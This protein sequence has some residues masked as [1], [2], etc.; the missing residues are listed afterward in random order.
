[1][2]G[3]VVRCNITRDVW[4][5]LERLFFSQSK[6]RTMQL[7]MALQ[8][9]RKGS[10]TME[11]YFLKMHSLADQLSAIGQVVTDDDL[12]MYILAGLGMEYEALVVNF[13]ERSESP[14]LQEMHNAF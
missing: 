2:L 5:T 7:Q 11:E 8:T 3:H 10:L 13:M 4:I 12:Q 14:S 9:M 6:A 1:M